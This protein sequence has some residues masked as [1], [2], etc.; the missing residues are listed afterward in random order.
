ML[1]WAPIADYKVNALAISPS[2]GQVVVGGAFST[3]NGSNR[4]GYGLG[5]V[6]ATTGALQPFPVNDTVR[7]AGNNAAILSLASDSQ[8]VYGT[9]YVFGSGGN[10]EGTFAAN[11]SDGRIK[12][13]EDCHGDTYGVFPSPTAVYTAGHAHY[14]GN[15][16]GFPETS[17]RSWHRAIAFG[18]AATGVLTRGPVRLSQLHRYAPLPHC[19]TGTPTWTPAPTPGRTKAPGR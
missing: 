10:F 15:L 2:G 7:D 8:T 16:G 6:S 4:P 5:A 3:L 18:K 11:W 12:W 13:L 9:G 19:S 17:P 1:P 14:C